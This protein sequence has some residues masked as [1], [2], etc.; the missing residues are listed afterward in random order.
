MFAWPHIPFKHPTMSLASHCK[1]SAQILSQYVGEQPTEGRDIPVAL[2]QAMKATVSVT[3]ASEG[4][5]INFLPAETD[6]IRD[7]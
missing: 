7:F 3:V 5:K 2:F 1:I 4:N 6:Q